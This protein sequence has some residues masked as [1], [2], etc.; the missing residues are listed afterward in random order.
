MFSVLHNQ[1]VSI[2]KVGRNGQRILDWRRSVPISF[3]KDHGNL[4]NDFAAEFVT[5]VLA[6]P[7]IGGLEIATRIPLSQEFNR[8]ISSQQELSPWSHSETR[9]NQRTDNYFLC[10]PSQPESE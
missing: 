7:D 1:H 6:W 9:V 3:H 10:F 4:I 8:R 2:G 5:H